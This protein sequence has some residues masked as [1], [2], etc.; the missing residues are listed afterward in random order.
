MPMEFTWYIPDRIL[1]IHVTGENHVV[2][3]HHFGEKA[4]QYLQDG[5]API[6]ILLDDA[7]AAPPPVSLTILKDAINL[8][9]SDAQSLGWVVGVGEGDMI[10]KVIFPMLTKVLGVK[11][12]RVATLDDAV[13]FLLQRDPTL[14]RF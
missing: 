6:H 9:P 8:R 14:P 7:D 2:D 13:D 4:Q 5:E 11:Y 10:V 1:H 3:L 12:T